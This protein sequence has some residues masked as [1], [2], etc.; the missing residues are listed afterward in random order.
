MFLLFDVGGTKT[1]FALSRTGENFATPE[2][3][4]TPPTPADLITKLQEV[5]KE[6]ATP[7]EAV[8]GGV[9]GTLDRAGG[10]LAAA[11]HLPGWVGEPLAEL[12]QQAFNCPVQLENDTALV[13]LGEAVAGA[14]RGA[15]IMVY[16]T[17]STGVGGA[18]IV[19]GK[20]DEHAFS[21]EPGQ[22]I[23]DYHQP[24]K[25]WE[26]YIS[27]TAVRAATGREPREITDLEFWRAL[28]PQV[29]VGIYNTILEWT[30]DRVVLGG[31]MLKTPGLDLPSVIAELEK[32]AANLPAI[33]ELRRAELGDLGGLH[34]ALAYL[35]QKLTHTS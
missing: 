10:R 8:V 1:R 31:G 14:G 19:A 9:A 15:E 33:P 6:E 4:T 27:G 21:F 13:G 20:I 25:H 17:I 23:I 34:G 35:N 22:Q 11:P 24:D 2:I 29:A 30:P 28:S 26:D 7:L 3:I 5:V 32:L 12:L 18:R 16:L